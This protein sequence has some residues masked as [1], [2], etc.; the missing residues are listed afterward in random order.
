MNYLL[1]TLNFRVTALSPIKY[2]V[3]K[4]KA[5]FKKLLFSWLLDLSYDQRT[6]D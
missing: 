2:F 4:E 6:F 3:E 1:V 5:A